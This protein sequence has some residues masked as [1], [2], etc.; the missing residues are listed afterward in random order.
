[1]EVRF[2]SKAYVDFQWA[3][4]C[5]VLKDITLNNELLGQLHMQEFATSLRKILTVNCFDCENIRFHHLHR[6][7]EA[8][9]VLVLSRHIIL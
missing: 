7:Y 9:H 1:M 6:R 5:Y 3:T 4:Q 8:L 2:S